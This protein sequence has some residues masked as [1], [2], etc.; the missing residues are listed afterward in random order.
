MMDFYMHESRNLV[1]GGYSADSFGECVTAKFKNGYGV[2]VSRTK[3]TYGNKQGEGL[4]E[5]AVTDR[6]GDFDYRT[7]VTYDVIG[8]LHP[9]DVR[10][11]V[12]EVARLPEAPL[13]PQTARAKHP[14][15]S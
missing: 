13:Y 15:M 2:S 8:W 6:F 3:G 10:E 11:Y 5:L 1:M 7:P 9:S 4:W 14:V 12:S